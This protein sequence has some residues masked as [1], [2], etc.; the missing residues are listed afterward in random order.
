M[1]FTSSPPY[2]PPMLS[3]VP[4]AEAQHRRTPHEFSLVS[5]PMHF[6]QAHERTFGHLRQPGR[7]IIPLKELG[8]G[9]GSLTRTVRRAADE[10]SGARALLHVEVPALATPNDQCGATGF[11]VPVA[12]IKPSTMPT[13][14]V[15]A[16]FTC[17]RPAALAVRVT[18]A[19]ALPRLAPMEAAATSRE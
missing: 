17:G 9:D 4:V 11:A 1:V 19:S 15:L 6:H 5:L 2:L 10:L 7:G 18:P 3:S 8:S 14:K 12:S 13:C 16:T